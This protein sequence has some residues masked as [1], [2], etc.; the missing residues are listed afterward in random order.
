MVYGWFCWIYI[1]QLV[2][3]VHQ[4]N[5]YV[6]FMDGYVRYTVYRIHGVWE[7]NMIG[8]CTTLQA[9]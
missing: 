3:E 7:A 9:L 8:G 5:V 2:G 6:W 4:V 1:S